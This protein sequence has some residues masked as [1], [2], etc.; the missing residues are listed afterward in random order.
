MYDIV[1]EVDFWVQDGGDTMKKGGL[2]DKGPI[3][4]GPVDP[5]ADGVR[6]A[7]R[8]AVVRLGRGGGV[9][10]EIKELVQEEE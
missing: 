6:A 1:D 9:T 3:A 5:E 7:V 8:E 2:G 10:G 4:L